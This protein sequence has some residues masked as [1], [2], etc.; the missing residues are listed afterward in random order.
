M[1]FRFIL[2]I[3]V[4]LAGIFYGKTVGLLFY[5]FLFFLDH[6]V[7]SVITLIVILFIIKKNENNNKTI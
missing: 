4:A 6:I 5:S 1:N 3:L 7:E 2:I